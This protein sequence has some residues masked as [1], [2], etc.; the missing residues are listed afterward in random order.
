MKKG[1]TLSLDI[2]KVGKTAST[3]LKRYNTVLF[4]VFAAIWVAFALI[5]VV[6]I[7]NQ[8]TDTS[9]GDAQIV[10]SSFDEPTMDRLK[11]LDS[12]SNAPLTF[13]N[14]RTNPFVE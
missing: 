1:P 7:N 8:A 11:R 9:P 6:V 5:I 13:P 4:I 10:D 14:E 3:F 2:Q 12:N